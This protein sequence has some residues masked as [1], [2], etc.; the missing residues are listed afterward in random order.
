VIARGSEAT[1]SGVRAATSG[2]AARRGRLLLYGRNM[3]RSIATVMAAVRSSTPRLAKMWRVSTSISRALR[4]RSTG[5]LA[6][7]ISFDATEGP[8]GDT[9]RLRAPLVTVSVKR[10]S[11]TME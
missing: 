9:D 8:R 6:R 1:Q 2:G 7:P 5:P 4:E 3:P 10:F 11:K